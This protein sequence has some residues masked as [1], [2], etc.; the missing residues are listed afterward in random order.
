M[1][2]IYGNGTLPFDP[3][4]FAGRRLVHHPV[5][6]GILTAGYCLEEF[7]HPENRFSA[8]QVGLSLCTRISGIGTED[9]IYIPFRTADG[10]HRFAAPG[11][12]FLQP[13]FLDRLIVH[14]LNLFG[15]L[16]DHFLI[17]PLVNHHLG[18]G[19]TLISTHPLKP[20]HTDHGGIPT[21]IN[22]LLTTQLIVYPLSSYFYQPTLGSLS[23][24]LR[25]LIISK[26]HPRIQARFL[27]Q[28]GIQLSIKIHMVRNM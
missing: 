21:A 22:D 20:K 4:S 13:T 3:K 9:M 15:I 19:L 7:E 1:V 18:T 17:Q 23:D 26:R 10:L 16:A 6:T 8:S 2:V 11:I 27:G 14:L 25:I 12:P 28:E 24:L 5:D